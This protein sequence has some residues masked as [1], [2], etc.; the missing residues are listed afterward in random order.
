MMIGRNSMT[1]IPPDGKWFA[2][3]V[4]SMALALSGLPC[5]DAAALTPAA[6]IAAKP[7]APDPRLTSFLRGADS[8]LK[9]GNINL[10]IIQLKN[11]VQLAPKQGEPRAR[12]GL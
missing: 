4:V 1:R 7:G 9:T 6:A 12:L 11:A 8:A 3:M 10:A 2:T 5:S